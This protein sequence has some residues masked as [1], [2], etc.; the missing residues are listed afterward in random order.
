MRFAFLSLET[1]EYLLPGL[2]PFIFGLS[3]YVSF[4]KEFFPVCFLRI[5]PVVP[6]AGRSDTKHIGRVRPC[7]RGAV[8]GSQRGS[9]DRNHAPLL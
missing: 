9:V 8:H 6:V 5:D 3:I 4:P 1:P 7:A 2:A